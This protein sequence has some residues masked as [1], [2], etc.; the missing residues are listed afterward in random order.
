MTRKVLDSIFFLQVWEEAD[1]LKVTKLLHF[2]AKSSLDN[3][4]PGNAENNSTKRTLEDA[5]SSPWEIVLCKSNFVIKLEIQCQ[6]NEF[7]V[8]Y[9]L[10][11][12]G[13]SDRY[14]DIKNLFNFVW[15]S[16]ILS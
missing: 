8:C 12:P 9:K 2:P 7:K 1:Y 15:I 16:F 3:T 10:N 6:D 14:T 4:I 13:V 5:D 11:V